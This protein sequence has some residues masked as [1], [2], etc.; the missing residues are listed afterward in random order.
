MT[1]TKQE[2]PGS[3]VSQGIPYTLR[4]CRFFGGEDIPSKQARKPGF[5]DELTDSDSSLLRLEMAEQNA[6]PFFLLMPLTPNLHNGSG[7]YH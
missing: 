1:K 3:V 7:E 2:F 4:L 5:P 6:W